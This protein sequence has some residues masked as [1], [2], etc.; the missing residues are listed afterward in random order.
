MDQVFQYATAGDGRFGPAEPVTDITPAETPQAFPQRPGMLDALLGQANSELSQSLDAYQLR[1]QAKP[2]LEKAP[3]LLFIPGGGFLSGTGMARWFTQADDDAAIVQV[4]VNYPLGVLGHLSPTGDP[5]ES[6]RP[7]RALVYALEWVKTH[8]QHYGGDPENVTLAGDSAGAWYSYALATLPETR[9][10]F[11]R[12]ALISFPREAPLSEEAYQQRWCAA[13]ELLADSGGLEAASISDILDAQTTLA[14]RFAG[15]G[16]AVMP[17]ANSQVPAALHDFARTV[18]K[19]HVDEL[20]LMVTADEAQ[21]FLHPAP[22][23]AFTQE[24]LTGY[25]EAHF[26]DP[27][28]VN[29]WLQARGELS[30]KQ[31]MAQLLTLYQFQLTQ[32]EVARAASLAGK[33]VYAAEFG[34]ASPLTGGSPHCMT[35]PF[36]FGNRQQW[37]DAPMLSGISDRVFEQASAAVRKWLHGFISDGRPRCGESNDAQPSFEPTAP[38]RLAFD[39]AVMDHGSPLMEKPREWD[40]AARYAVDAV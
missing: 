9:G 32:V 26:E 27:E 30:P 13:E 22:E 37:Q 19:L 12:L 15:R 7:L 1:V 4:T 5:E 14:R 18:P 16:M 11:R 36:L 21:A 8:I 23:A 6:D 35:L 3:V 40:L 25:I 10:L 31:Q 2:G 39:P 17:A 29:A 24:D 38:Q 33:R 28:E 34:V 20:L